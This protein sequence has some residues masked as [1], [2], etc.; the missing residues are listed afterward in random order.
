MTG[1]IIG[2]SGFIGKNLT[3]FYGNKKCDLYL[4]G[5][6][7]DILISTNRN[8]KII[9]KGRFDLLTKWESKTKVDLVFYLI[10]NSTNR[11]SDLD[12]E[13]AL[14]DHALNL[15]V[16]KQTKFIFFSSA[17]GIYENSEEIKTEEMPLSPSNDYEKTKVFLE[18][19]LNSI[20]DLRKNILIV[21]PS[22]VYGRYQEKLVNKNGLITTIIYNS[23]TSKKIIIPKNYTEIYRDYLHIEDLIVLISK[24]LEKNIYGV[25]NFSYG[26]SFSIQKIIEII[27]KESEKLNI[28]L[29]MNFD[30]AEKS[31]KTN[32]FISNQKIR[33]SIKSE[34]KIDVAT[35]I[36]MQIIY[37]NELISNTRN[38]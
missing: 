24:A 26:E 14:I 7:N 20:K 4:Y 3:Q 37:L 21:R 23:L 19:H 22:N 38:I 2:H 17:G 8:N 35:G 13:K 28:P 33:N 9:E 25:Y 11:N 5:N 1:I 6:Q 15:F 31:S 30:F 16:K 27:G 34:P 29:V 36:R 12:H 18:Q 32:S 10:S